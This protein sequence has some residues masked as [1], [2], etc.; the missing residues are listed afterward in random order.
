MREGNRAMRTVEGA[1]TED[2][3]MRLMRVDSVEDPCTLLRRSR[4]KRRELKCGTTACRSRP[5]RHGSLV[6]P[7]M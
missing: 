7:T 2:L 4:V 1:G 3:K 5:S 6:S